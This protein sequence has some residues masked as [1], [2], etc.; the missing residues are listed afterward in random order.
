MKDILAE[1]QQLIR[2]KK[3]SGLTRFITVHFRHKCQQHGDAENVS[4]TH[5]SD[6]ELSNFK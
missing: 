4:R 1:F 2:I 5:P 6:D 3:I